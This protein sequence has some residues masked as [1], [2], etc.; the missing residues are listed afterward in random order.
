MTES[1]PETMEKKKSKLCRTCNDG[2]PL[3]CKLCENEFVAF[4]PQP[5]L[6][7]FA[8]C[9]A[10]HAALE[11]MVDQIEEDHLNP[12]KT[13]PTSSPIVVVSIQSRG[14]AFR[15]VTRTLFDRH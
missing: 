14:S 5:L 9:P 1:D 3:L 2:V 7:P 13:P 8:T 12:K 15:R 10:C 6:C 11:K 4:L